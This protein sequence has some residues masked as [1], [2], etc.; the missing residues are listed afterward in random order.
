LAKLV[1]DDGAK[2]DGFGGGYTL[3]ERF[4]FGNVDIN[5]GRAMIGAPRDDDHGAST[6]SA[7]VYD[8]SNGQLQHKLST[9]LTS[10]LDHLGF[11]VGLAGNWAVVGTHPLTNP[12]NPPEAPGQAFLFDL[13][14]ATATRRL[15]SPA[16]RT[17]DDFGWSLSVDGD[18]AVIGAQGA[19]YLFDLV[20]GAS[21][22]T[23]GGD[24]FADEFGR[25]V[26]ISGDYVVVGAFR[27]DSA[28][29]RSAGNCDAGAAYVFDAPTGS[30]QRKLTLPNA[31][32]GDLFGA[33]VALDGRIAAIG[34]PGRTHD[35]GRRGSAFTLDVT[36][37][38]LLSEFTV[39]DIPDDQWFGG[40][41]ALDGSSLVVGA[42][43]HVKATGS[44]HL[45]DLNTGQRAARLDSTGVLPG[46]FFG[47]AVAV[48]DGLAMVAAPLADAPE[49]NSGAVYL[50][51][52]MD[53]SLLPGD[54]NQDFVFDQLDLVQVQQAS[55][56]LTDIPATWGEGDW[57]G[58]PGGEPG[59]PPAGDGRFNQLDIVAAL[60]ADIYLTGPYRA[61]AVDG[62]AGHVANGLITVPEPSAFLLTAS[63]LIGGTLASRRLFRRSARHR[64]HQ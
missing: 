43:S 23:L 54:A 32:E 20:D 16:S 2:N 42:V 33:S 34:A 35:S 56:Y 45:F 28:C 29:P 64:G 63:A 18:R 30:R 15:V 1:P 7:Y 58:G 38:E 11:A 57:N 49:Q 4:E 25:S 46:D 12:L 21:T 44:A 41:V 26:A 53:R 36:T 62:L 61:N 37:G 5:Q 17:E 8:L 10:E 22:A 48:E 3:I 39:E 13:S 19:A 50:F 31:L 14:G 59:T 60:N 52:V 47:T 51:D 24:S 9:P 55:K 40:T 6:G 27:D